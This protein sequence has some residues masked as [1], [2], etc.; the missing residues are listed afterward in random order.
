MCT[1]TETNSS[2]RNRTV[3]TSITKEKLLQTTPKPKTK[4]VLGAQ[5]QP[6]PSW[7]HE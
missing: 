1:F 5:R 4:E 3:D 2:Q 7:N 6:F